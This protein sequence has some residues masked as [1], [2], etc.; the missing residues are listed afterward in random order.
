[1]VCR[2][3]DCLEWACMHIAR[4]VR[5][6]RDMRESGVAGRRSCARKEPHG[7]EQAVGPRGN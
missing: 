2:L 4:F 7:W 5:R 6:R 1:M 3:V